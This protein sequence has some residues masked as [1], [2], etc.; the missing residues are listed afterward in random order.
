M[1]RHEQGPSVMLRWT[2]PSVGDCPLMVDQDRALDTGTV[3][4]EGHIPKVLHNQARDMSNQIFSDWCL[5]QLG[6]LIY[7][8]SVGER[9]AVER[10]APVQGTGVLMAFMCSEPNPRMGRFPL[11]SVLSCMQAALVR[12]VLIIVPQRQCSRRMRKCCVSLSAT[13]NFN[14]TS[15]A[16]EVL[17]F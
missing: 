1:K 2:P 17:S 13:G 5:D 15:G 4:K 11:A 12:A 16:Q 6:R 7:Q 10:P 8:P 9:I 3:V 14:W